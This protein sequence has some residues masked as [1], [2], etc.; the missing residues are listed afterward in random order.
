MSKELTLDFGPITFQNRTISK[1]QGSENK[2]YKKLSKHNYQRAPKIENDIELIKQLVRDCSENEEINLLSKAFD[3]PNV[4]LTFIDQIVEIY[5]S[6]WAITPAGINSLMQIKSNGVCEEAW[7]FL[8]NTH[9]YKWMFASGA[10]KILK[11]SVH[12]KFAA[13]HSKFTCMKL[14]DGSVLNLYGSMNLSNNPRWE[15]ISINKSIE[16]FRFYSEFVK[17]VTGSMVERP[18]H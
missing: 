4:I 15:N 9:S 12:I 18:E 8:D 3:S 7:L 14:V 13:N 10:Y 6:T 17:T 11:D 1:Q 2:L 5:V 16:D